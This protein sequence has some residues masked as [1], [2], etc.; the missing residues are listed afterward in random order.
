VS[1]PLNPPSTPIET[2]DIGNYDEIPIAEILKNMVF[3][4]IASNV[5]DPNRIS[6]TMDAFQNHAVLTVPV[7]RGTPGD[8]GQDAMVMRFEPVVVDDLD[9]LPTDLGDYVGDLGKFYVH[10]IVDLVT[11]DA[12]A[13]TLYVWTGTVDGPLSNQAGLGKGFVQLPVGTPGSPGVYPDITPNLVVQE[14]G[15]GL[16]PYGVDSWVDTTILATQV[17]T[18]TGTPTAGSFALITHIGGVAQT[19]GTIAYNNI[20]AGTIQSALAALST[21]GTGNVAVTGVGSGPFTVA[22]DVGTIDPQTVA[23]MTFTSTLTGATVRIDD[24]P[25]NPAMTFDLAVPPGETGPSSPLGG[26][27]DVDFQTNG[28]LKTNDTVVC[29]SRTTPSAPSGL[30]GTASTTGGTIPAGTYYYVVTAM[31]P[32]GET[33]ASNEISKTTTGS[34]S[35]VALTWNAPSGSGSTGYRVYRGTS[36]G[37]EH[38]L[39]AV[40]SRGTQTSFTDVGNPVATASPPTTGITSGM[41][42]WVNQAQLAAGAKIYTM[43]ESA[44]TSGL[45]ISFLP[46]LLG[47]LFGFASASEKTVGVFALPQQPWP[48][49]PMVFGAVSVD[50]LSLSLTPLQAEA[51]VRLADANTGLVVGSGSGS[52]IGTVTVTPDLGTASITPSNGTAVVPANHTGSMGT[53]FFNLVNL[54]LADFYA[55]NSGKNAQ[56]VVLVVPLVS[57]VTAIGSNV[58]LQTARMGTPTISTGMSLTP[59]APVTLVK[60]PKPTVTVV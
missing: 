51:R 6:L 4:G 52:S 29:T 53:L 31:V 27:I 43:P 54:G 45:D 12:I 11:G 8:P 39:V 33:V 56:L 28:P 35:S 21:V 22:F 5:S 41:P 15:S 55:Y 18:I 3:T 34:T 20:S 40:I 58:P 2:I 1:A 17:V 24:S 9:Q 50:G 37:A 7:L 59:S 48:W 46:G 32:N 60:M 47:N 26:F 36:T 10:K 38:S 30:A 25:A 44:F 19:A 57:G 49:V 16:G 14:L 13:T 23:L 42:I